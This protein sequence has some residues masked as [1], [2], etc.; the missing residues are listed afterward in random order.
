[1]SANADVAQIRSFLNR[2]E[3]RLGAIAATEGAAGGVVLATVVLLLR[4]MAPFSTAVTAALVVLSIVTGIA[5][6]YFM[7]AEQRRQAA[8]AV[9]R[10]APACHN[11]VVA[12]NEIL[13]YPER[14]RE[15]VA[16]LVFRQAAAAVRSL[17]VGELFPVKRTLAWLTGSVA[18]LVLVLVIHYTGVPSQQA[19]R[20]VSANAVPVLSRVDIAVEAPGYARRAAL[21]LRDPLRVE[22]LAG[23]KISITVKSNAS[24]VVIETIEKKDTLTSTGNET[25]TGTVVANADGF[26]AIEPSNASGKGTRKLIGLT[27]TPDHAPRVR[28]T[29]PGKDMIYPD[30]NRSLPVTAEADDDIGLGSLKLR[31][32]KVSGSGE[33]FTFTEGEVPLQVSRNKDVN[34]T[35]QARWNLASLQLEAGDMVVYRAVATDTR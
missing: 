10:A 12:A 23:S 16:V 3:K 8:L 35:A 14:V 22:A 21:S 32:T 13:V 30:G 15:Y 29:A 18:T 26:V 2:V 6:R 11:L 34:W 27:V 5:V 24:I 9:E 20:A 1:M 31:Y 4:W 7:L 28:L 19:R 17:D 33:R 25:F